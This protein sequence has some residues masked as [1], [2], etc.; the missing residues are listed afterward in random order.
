M[1]FRYNQ[2]YFFLSKLKLIAKFE[3][4][5]YFVE[6]ENASNIPSECFEV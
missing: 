1:L 2:R 3:L 5:R 4:F 6:M